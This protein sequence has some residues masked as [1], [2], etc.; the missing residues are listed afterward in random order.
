MSKTTLEL[1]GWQKSE[2]GSLMVRKNAEGKVFC[3]VEKTRGEIFVSFMNGEGKMEEC[4]EPFTDS[5]KAMKRCEDWLAVNY[6]FER[7]A[8]LYRE[9]LTS[10]LSGDQSTK[11]ERLQIELSLM[12]TLLAE[13]KSER[14][15]STTT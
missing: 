11:L 9:R 5:N 6:E 2:D 12:K 13:G 8:E 3:C 4:P 14:I 15:E 10:R 7:D 1:S